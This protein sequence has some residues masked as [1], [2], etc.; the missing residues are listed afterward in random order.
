VL[1][2]VSAG[3]DNIEAAPLRSLH[4]AVLNGEDNRMEAFELVAPMRLALTSSSA[5]LLFANHLRLNSPSSVFLKAETAGSALGLC[6]DEPFANEP[7]A[8]FC[9]RELIDDDLVSTA[10]HC[11]GTGKTNR[12]RDPAAD[13]LARETH[14]RNSRVRPGAAVV[15]AP[16]GVVKKL[17][18]V[19]GVEAL[20]LVV[21]LVLW[22]GPRVAAGPRSSDDT[23]SNAELT[24][25]VTTLR[26]RLAKIASEGASTNAE[27]SAEVLAMQRRLAEI[28]RERAQAKPPAIAEADVS[29]EAEAKP[30]QPN[31]PETE[32]KAFTAYFS[33]LDGLRRAEGVDAPWAQ[34]MDTAVRRTLSTPGPMSSLSAQSIDCGRTLCRIELR[35]SNPTQKQL[36]LGQLLMKEGTDLPQASVFVPVD[37]DQVIAYFARAGVNL[38]AM[39][40]A[41]QGDS[42]P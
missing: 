33:R 3:C 40:S 42:V 9:S 12:P 36:G 31:T 10:G 5:A 2:V 15:R 21:V 20:V 34:A 11:F 27:L 1:C 14:E 24:A 39:D 18:A 22:P 32:A 8:A 41:E 37:S 35:C 4:Q 7:S 38:P 19:I 26:R 23:A 25:E 6:P 29:P 28:E 17:F 16:Q 30:K 13:C